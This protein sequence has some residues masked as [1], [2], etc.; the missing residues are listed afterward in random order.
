M[1][2]RVC[3]QALKSR[4]SRVIACVDA[5][6]VAQ[7]LEGTPGVKVC[8]T[9]PNA[10]SGTDRIASMIAIEGLDP[11][12]IIVNIQGDEPLIDPKHIDAV[13]E[14]LVEKQADMATLCFKIDNQE[15]LMD[16]SCVKVV[17]NKQGYAMYFSR[18]PIPYERD[19][20]AA[21]RPSTFNHYHH[22]GIYAYRAKTVTY[23][24]SLEQSE[25][26][27]AESLEQL[28]ILDEGMSIAVG[29]VDD[30]PETGV[31]TQQDLDRI[32]KLLAERG[33]A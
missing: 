17:M 6:K 16:P 12:T 33:E 7:V 26:E 10:Q 4:A 1:V 23:F 2:K 11:D 14:L 19:N 13:A 3:L 24:N 5:P 22:I 30:P 29:I 21:G 15:D 31:D 9:D 18:A 8:M 28:R 20:F 25:C 27:K 32:N